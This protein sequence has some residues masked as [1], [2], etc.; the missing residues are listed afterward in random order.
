LR[1]DVDLLEVLPKIHEETLFL[2]R[3]R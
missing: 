2:I 3:E 1:R